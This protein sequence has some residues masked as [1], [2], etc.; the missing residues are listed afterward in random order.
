M[1]GATSDK[2]VCDL[3][4]I[5]SNTVD[6]KVGKYTYYRCLKCTGVFAH[7]KKTQEFYLGN[8][9]YLHDVKTYASHIDPYGQRWMIEQCERLYE[10]KLPPLRRGSFFEI[11]AG[12]GYLTLMALARG[13][14][15]SGIETSK[16]AVEYANDNLRVDIKHST[17]EEYDPKKTFDAI[18]LVEVLEHFLSPL[19]AFNAIKRLC[20]EYTFVF[21]TTPNT[22]SLHWQKSEQDIYQPKDHLF[23]F[24][25]KSIRH[26][27]EKAGIKELTV[28]LF[29]SGDEHDSNLMY[30][31][32]MS[33]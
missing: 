17:I 23:L 16:Q 2:P 15:A 26:F 27:A 5:T 32:I 3:C 24:N 29:G 18:A 25:E 33:A 10:Q 7:P 20:G 22:G 11:G 6:R 12:A 31:G 14:Q 21:G 9:T 1:S 13:W 19:E 8:E 30:A 4:N 28:E